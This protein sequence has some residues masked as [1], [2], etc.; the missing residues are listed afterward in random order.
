M[1]NVAG[2][3]VCKLHNF[4]TN[5]MANFWIVPPT[6]ARHFLQ[7]FKPLARYSSFKKNNPVNPG[8]SHRQRVLSNLL[9][10]SAADEAPESIVWEKQRDYAEF[11]IQPAL[12]QEK[13]NMIVDYDLTGKYMK[14][15]L[16]WESDLS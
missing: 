8:L 6:K 9:D 13:R 12:S 10:L 1:I 11:P 16:W 4:G 7:F 5:A 15:I 14:P 3:G 2:S